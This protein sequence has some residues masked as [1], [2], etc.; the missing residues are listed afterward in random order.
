ME[1]VLGAAL[2]GGLTQTTFDKDNWVKDEVVKYI[3]GT[4]FF[5]RGTSNNRSWGEKW[6]PTV[7]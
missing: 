2:G 5:P 4:Y 6:V 7:L 3:M 1:S